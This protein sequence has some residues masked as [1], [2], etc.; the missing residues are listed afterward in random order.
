MTF[1]V[2][3]EPFTANEVRT[4]TFDFADYMPAGVTIASK[5]AAS[6]VYSG[7]DLTPDI[8]QSSAISGTTVLVVCG[9]VSVGVTYNLVVKATLSNGDVVEGAAY[10]A[11]VPT[12]V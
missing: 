3:V 8:V 9:S 12:L 1:R 10:V 6:T 5:V 11:G 2:L 4:L 7:T